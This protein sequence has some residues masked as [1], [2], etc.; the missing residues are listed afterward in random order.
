MT[1]T[2]T[3]EKRAGF[4][5]SYEKRRSARWAIEYNLHAD[6]NADNNL[7]PYQQEPYSY[8]YKEYTSSYTYFLADFT[9]HDRPFTEQ[10]FAR[11][12]QSANVFLKWYS[13]DVKL[14]R[15]SRGLLRFK[16]FAKG[17]PGIFRVTQDVKVQYLTGKEE[18]LGYWNGRYTETRRQNYYSEEITG[19]RLWAGVG[20][21]LDM[22]NR[23]FLE[24]SGQSG[25]NIPVSRKER[26]IYNESLKR[27]GNLMEA[28]SGNAALKLGFRF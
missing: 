13:K 21:Q 10:V 8:G 22:G 5:I 28:F 19:A 20:L 2:M 7:T 14:F 12:E 11:Q 25:F 24:L 4:Q 3:P 16:G 15:K 17:G 1:L 27:E 9:I 26:N 18:P 23:I 6:F